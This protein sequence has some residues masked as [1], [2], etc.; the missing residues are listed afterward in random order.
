VL[1][2]KLVLVELV[3]VVVVVVLLLAV[4]LPH[5]ATAGPGYHFLLPGRPQ[6]TLASWLAVSADPSYVRPPPRVGGPFQNM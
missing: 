4:K 1:A 6:L 5:S 3:V 2:V